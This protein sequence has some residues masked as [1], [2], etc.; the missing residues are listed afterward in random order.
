MEALTETQSLTA[1]NYCQ[2][3]VF[4]ARTLIDALED[5]LKAEGKFTLPVFVDGIDPD[6]PIKRIRYMR[7]AKD[8][9]VGLELVA[10]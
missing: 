5:I 6:Q 10:E 2:R 3:D 4:T 7:G 9:I 8:A 1:T